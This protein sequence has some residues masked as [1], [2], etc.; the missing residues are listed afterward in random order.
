MKKEKRNKKPYVTCSIVFSIL[1]VFCLVVTIVLTQNSFLF[2]TI[3][4]VIGG[5]ERYLKEGNPEDYQYYTADYENKS[6]TLAAANE[7]NEKIVQ[8]GI[9]LLKNEEE[10]LPLKSEKKITVFGKN[11]ANLVLGGS[12]S[13]SGSSASTKVD[14][15]ASL[16]AAGFECNPVM[17]A[18]YADNAK[19]GKGRPDVPSMGDIITGF[20]IAETPISSYTKEVKQSYASYNDAAIVILSRIG[21][22][23]Y[24]LPRT[25]YW[26][27]MGYTD[28]SGSQLIPGAK[29]KDSHY[30]ELDQNE[31]DML[32]E[33]CDNF[34][35]VIVVFNSASTIE[36]GFLSD[37]AF[38]NVSGAL[39]LGD[40]GVS[41]IDALGKVLNGSVN[42]SGRTVDTFVKDFTQ[43]PT[44]YNFGNNRVSN[45]NSYTRAGKELRAWFVEYRE[46]IYTG[47]HYYETRGY[48]EGG[49]WYDDNVVYPFG[50][51]L[52]YTQFTNRATSALADGTTLT[53]D[54]KL[55]FEVEVTN[56]G[57][58]YD[59]KEVVQLYYSAPYTEGG[60]EKSHVNLGAFAKTDIIAKNNGT[61]TVTVELDVRDMASY[62]YNDANGNGFKGYELEEGEYTIYIVGGSDGSHCWAND[63]VTKF[64]F[65]VPAGGFRYDGENDAK[66][67]FDDVSG[68]IAQENYLSRKNNFAN[69][70]N[71]KGAFSAEN[72]DK[73]SAFVSSLTYVLNDRESDP[74]YASEAPAQSS[75]ELSYQETEVKLFHL[76]GKE[77]ND[78]LW[79]DLLDQLTVSQMVRLISTGNYRTLEIENIDKPLTTDPDGPMG[80]SVFMG[81]PTVY[82]TCYYASECVLAAT[83]NVELA[84][85]MGKMI[86]NEGVIGNEAGDG[87]PYA[88]WY[89]PAVNLHRS[90][91]GG[92]NFE[93]YSEDARL[94][95]S[96]ATNVI[97]GAKSKGVY[98]YLKHFA[99]NEQ[100]T[101]RDETGLIT[102]ANEQSMREQ[103]FLPFEMC[104]R[105][106]GTNAMMSSFNRLGVT[107]TGGSYNLLTGL[108]RDEW[109][110][111]GMVITDYN[112]KPYMNADQMIRA[113]GDLNLSAGKGPSS[114][115]TAT[116]IASLRR[117]TKNILFTVANSCAMNGYGD[118]VVWGYSAPWWVGCLMALDAI[119]FV[120]AAAM[121]VLNIQDKKKQKK[122]FLA[123][124]D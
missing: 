92:R 111:E 100:E 88:G 20:P 35:K 84:Y 45:G 85:E 105:E 103:Y 40:P 76:I 4:S 89:A 75:R 15:C 39:W 1:F 98:T 42:P 72:R 74:W 50:Y 12:G 113:G 24:D 54:G 66:N 48:T 60:I 8:E 116:D 78:P 109:G 65:N 110:F 38:A 56:I 104:V 47:Y 16:N 80:Y 3:C 77:Y 28:W 83:F 73:D 115:T 71:I 119:S 91:F 43:D 5:S 112:L 25:M 49:S 46:G 82:D 58:E 118:G 99:L 53:Q 21:G 67:L 30:L 6:Q 102:W 57:N 64:T 32:K 52:S 37:P 93:Y 124:E 44:W 19:S 61:D 36:L 96:M 27:G 94:S 17:K 63:G 31:T 59:G 9:I 106:G 79:D 51:G 69:F 121:I 29:S 90:Q 70:D 41:G 108:L 107:W 34:E 22:E 101:K 62:D 86:G 18:F 114:Q 95:G 81:D 87:R 14:V 2:Y 123:L 13:N 55:S 10:A 68:G 11:S 33:A 120:A 117:A 26:N 122:I 97:K 7:L 23:G